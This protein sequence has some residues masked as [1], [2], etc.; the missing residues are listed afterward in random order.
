MTEQDVQRAAIIARAQAGREA[1]RRARGMEAD[2]LLDNSRDSIGGGLALIFL[3]RALLNACS[4]RG[5]YSTPT[6]KIPG[7]GT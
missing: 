1:V 2:P 5:A 3:Q 7:R 6:C 4:W